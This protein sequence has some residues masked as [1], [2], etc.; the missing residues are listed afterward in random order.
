MNDS[1]SENKNTSLGYNYRLPINIVK[2]IFKK[3]KEQDIVYLYAY[4]SLILSSGV[5][6]T[7]QRRTNIY[8][9]IFIIC[10]IFISTQITNNLCIKYKENIGIFKTVIIIQTIAISFLVS[11]TGFFESPFMLFALNPILIAATS[12][13]SV[14]CWINLGLFITSSLGICYRFTG[15][16]SL[17]KYNRHH[18]IL[19]FVLITLVVQL[20]SKLTKELSLKA[21]ILKEKNEELLDL[22]EKLE[23]ANRLIALQ[24]QNRIAEEMH[25][26][27]C[28]QLFSIVCALHSLSNKGDRLTKSELSY[29]LS[30][31][32]ECARNTLTE[33]R[34]TIYSLSSLKG[35][36]KE[37]FSYI[38]S[39]LSNISKLNDVSIEFVHKG[40]EQSIPELIKKTLYRLICE[41]TN[42]AIRHGNC[43]N[44]KLSLKAERDFI[45]LIVSD[46]GKGFNIKKL[47]HGEEAGL[48]IHNMKSLVQ[49]LNGSIDIKSKLKEGTQ[50]NIV[51]PLRENFEEGEKK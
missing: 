4:I 1:I 46:D 36:E 28:Q 9:K 26:N 30:F 15:S 10:S 44:V 2:N 7:E 51:I 12:L 18:L 5:Y 11:V 6:L 47:K 35:Q 20:L 48:G 42:N 41:T 50:I 34:R 29:N 37:F 19:I 45:N 39:Y 13:S 33:L 32:S 49:N 16:I 14:F 22:N 21:K 25:D 38:D 24:E 17:M 23:E 31:I 27:V 3:F 43:K 40:K 8:L